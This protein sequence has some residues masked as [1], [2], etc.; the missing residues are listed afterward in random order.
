[1][2]IHFIHARSKHT[3]AL[4][5]VMTHGWPGSVIEFMEIVAPLTT[6]PRM[7]GVPRTRSTLSRRRDAL[8]VGCLI[9]DGLETGHAAF[10]PCIVDV[11][12]TSLDHV[13]EPIET[14]IC[15]GDLALEFGQVL[16]TALASL[17]PTI[18]DGLQDG[19][20]ALGP[21]NRFSRWLATRSSRKGIEIDL[22]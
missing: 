4:P 16:A 17:L 22:P 3:N 9:L 19:C 1:M 18:K 7:A 5:I 8:G 13:I 14:Q 10:E 20:Q 15:L 12:H 21:E 11:G 2:G 6:R